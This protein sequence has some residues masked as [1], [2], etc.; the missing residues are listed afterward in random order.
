MIKSCK[1]YCIISIVVLFIIMIIYNKKKKYINN[2]ELI[3]ES[4]YSKEEV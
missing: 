1:I 3:G 4:I 2:K